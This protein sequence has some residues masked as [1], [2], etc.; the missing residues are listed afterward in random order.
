MESIDHVKEQGNIE[1]EYVFPFSSRSRKFLILFFARWFGLILLPI[2]SFAGDGAVAVLYFIRAAVNE[3]TKKPEELAKGRAIDLSV[4][5]TL[6]WMPFFTLLGWWINKP[7]S[8]LF[9]K[10]S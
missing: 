4:Q 3:G 5:F 2:V 9:G 7:L 10:L 8:M 1:Q 6:F